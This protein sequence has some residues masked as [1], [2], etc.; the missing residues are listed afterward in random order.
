MTTALF[1]PELI[2]RIIEREQL[3]VMPVIK[4]ITL[5]AS[6]MVGVHD[7][8]LTFDY[9]GKRVRYQVIHADYNQDRTEVTFQLRLDRILNEG[10]PE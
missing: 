2:R 7:S 1:N 6:S 3:W 8:H 10:D 9:D 4:S 5:D